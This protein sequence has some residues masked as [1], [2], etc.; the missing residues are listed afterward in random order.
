[1]NLSELQAEVCPDAFTSSL[2]T[3]DVTDTFFGPQKLGYLFEWSFEFTDVT[4]S[5]DPSLNNNFKLYSRVSA[6]TGSLT[7]RKLIYSYSGSSASIHEPSYFV[8][9]SPTIVIEDW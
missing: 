6:N 4:S 3:T 8:G 5:G 1:M 7:T 9:G 2:K